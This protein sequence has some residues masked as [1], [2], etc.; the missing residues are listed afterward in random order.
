[1]LIDHLSMNYLAHGYRFT[2]DP[3]FLAGTAVPDW[4]RVA[5]PRLGQRAAAGAA[6]GPVSRGNPFLAGGAGHRVGE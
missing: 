1:M 6:P 4:L 3:L 5:A 2:E